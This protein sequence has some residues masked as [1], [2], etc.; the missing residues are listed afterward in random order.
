MG[1]IVACFQLVGNLPLTQTSLNHWRRKSNEHENM[2]EAFLEIRD[3]SH[4]DQ[5]MYCEIS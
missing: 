1:I 3:V 5:H 2:M 4:L